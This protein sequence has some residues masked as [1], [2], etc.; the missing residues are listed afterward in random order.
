VILNNVPDGARLVIEC[1]SAMNSKILGHRD[2]DILY[3][4]MVPDGLEKRV[5]ESKEHEILDR[6]FAKVMVDPKDVLLVEK[7]VNYLV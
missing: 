4:P 7:S 1:P 5:R 6:I 3:V 2:L